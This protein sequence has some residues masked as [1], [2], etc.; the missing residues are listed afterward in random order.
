MPALREAQTSFRARALQCI[1]RLVGDIRQTFVTGGEAFG[2]AAPDIPFEF[3]PGERKAKFLRNLKN[4]L[5]RDFSASFN[6]YWTRA[7]SFGSF[8]AFSRNCKG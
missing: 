2:H 6:G 8:W 5:G 4:F 1:S 3:A 7:L